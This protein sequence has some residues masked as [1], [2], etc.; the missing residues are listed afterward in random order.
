MTNQEKAEL[1]RPWVNP[2]ERITVDFTDVQ[3]LNAL[4]EGCTENVVHL[5]FQET[6]PHLKERITVPL[7]IVTVDEDP[8][9]YTRDPRHTIQNRLRLHVEQNQPEGL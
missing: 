9:H 3:G 1:I 4:V 5:T 2:N 7:R 6:F 8:Y